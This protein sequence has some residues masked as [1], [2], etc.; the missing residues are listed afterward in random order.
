MNV[1]LWVSVRFP[2]LFLRIISGCSKRII[3]SIAY[4]CQQFSDSN[5]RFFYFFFLW[6][7]PGA[8][9]QTDMNSG[10]PYR[11]SM[12]SGNVLCSIDSCI[13]PACPQLT[14]APLGCV[15]TWPAAHSLMSVD[16]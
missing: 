6:L 13:Y 14:S 9:M 3:S 12:F 16:E 1:Q 8:C 11:P 5:S 15:V 10:P 4:P 7:L 2:L